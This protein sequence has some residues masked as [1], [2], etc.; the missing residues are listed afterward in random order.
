MVSNRNHLYKIHNF[1][2]EYYNILFSNFELQLFIKNVFIDL[3]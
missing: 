3:F 2:L 1:M